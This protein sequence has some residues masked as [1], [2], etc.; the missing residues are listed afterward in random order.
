MP[1]LE[2]LLQRLE[3][4]GYKRT[5]PRRMLLAEIARRPGPFTAA[6]I[7]AALQSQ[8]AGIGRATV[9]RTLDLL[10]EIGLVQR[11]HDEQ[12]GG[13]SAAY[14]ACEPVHHHH[15]ICSSCHAVWDFVE[16]DLEASI[17]AVARRNAFQMRE[18]RLELYGVCAA[19]REQSSAEQDISA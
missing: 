11:M 15:I 18:H 4:Q 13:V 12:G 7:Y 8:E 2:T 14:L 6:E 17:A 5:T 19:C 10:A 3:D 16:G 1:D 9:F